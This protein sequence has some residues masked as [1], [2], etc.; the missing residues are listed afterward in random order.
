MS[1]KEDPAI[2]KV[3][4]DTY[5]LYIDAESYRLLAYEYTVGYG[6]LLDIMR[7]PGERSYVGPVL[8]HIDIY[9]E[10]NGLTYHYQMHITDLQQSAVFGQHVLIDYAF[11]KKITD[12]IGDKPAGAVI[13]RSS[14][15]RMRRGSSKR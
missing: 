4:S 15:E 8:R 12:L 9:R 14:G 13:D 2:G 10:V 6:A 11:D 1:F 3:K 5:R 7:M